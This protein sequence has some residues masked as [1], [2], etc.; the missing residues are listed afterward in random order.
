MHLI[1]FFF[2]L[3]H[4]FQK[5]LR[6]YVNR[7]LVIHKLLV[8]FNQTEWKS[9]SVS[10]YISYI[11]GRVLTLDTLSLPKIL[12]LASLYCLVTRFSSTSERQ[13]VLQPPCWALRECAW[14]HSWVS[15]LPTAPLRSVEM[16]PSYHYNR[17]PLWKHAANEEMQTYLK[18]EGY[19]KCE[20]WKKIS[21]LVGGKNW[22]FWV[23]TLVQVKQVS[24]PVISFFEI[25]IIVFFFK[26]ACISPIFCWLAV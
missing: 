16:W 15:D 23:L 12:R 22:D 17:S 11:L 5:L 19:K 3:L 24:V 21:L 20:R 13:C 25:I 26:P 7:S 14:V 10:L 1:C 18:W 4:F 8:Y 2:L 6:N 9:L